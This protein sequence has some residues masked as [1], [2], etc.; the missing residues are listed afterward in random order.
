MRDGSGSGARARRADAGADAWGVG[1]VGGAAAMVGHAWPVF[2]QFRG[3][4]SVLTFVGAA[5][6]LS[7][8]A[9]ALAIGACGLVTAATGSFAYGARAGV[10]GFPVLQLLVDRP[11]R[12]AATGALM[13][14]IGLRFALAART[15]NSGQP[16]RT[17]A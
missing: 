3:G 13:G 8:R 2:A 10:F 17:A 5:T 11:Q 16:A 4:R 9:A 12:V 7:P 15:V 6:V 14:I 1:Y